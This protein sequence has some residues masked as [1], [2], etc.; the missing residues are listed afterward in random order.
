MPAEAL[1]HALAGGSSRG[2]VRLLESYGYALLREGNFKELHAWLQAVGRKA[3]AS[4]A[5]LNALNAWTQLYLGDAIAA[6]EAIDAAQAVLD[7]DAAVAIQ[8]AACAGWR[9]S[10]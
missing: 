7:L 2:A 10:C 4:S 5:E 8:R 9:T 1:R 6:S 3:V